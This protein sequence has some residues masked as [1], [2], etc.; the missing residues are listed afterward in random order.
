MSYS[1]QAVITK[2]HE[3]GSLF[4]TVLRDE[5]FKIN[6]PLDSVFDE[7]Q[8]SDSHTVHSHHALAG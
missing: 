8:I 4:L 1:V 2:H 3:M 6:L 7:E 5:E